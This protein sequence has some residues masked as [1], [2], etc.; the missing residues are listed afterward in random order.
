MDNIQQKYYSSVDKI[1]QKYYS[2][3]DKIQQKYYSI[4]VQILQKYYRSVVIWQKYYSSWSKIQK[5]MLELQFLG[6]RENPAQ[7]DS[8]RFR[9]VI[10]RTSELR[11][12][13][14]LHNTQT[15]TVIHT[16]IL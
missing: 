14:L 1:Q 12:E 9:F 3:V 15:H 4:V 6:F 2:S 16:V 7:F 10:V 13:T 5:V 8:V 11:V